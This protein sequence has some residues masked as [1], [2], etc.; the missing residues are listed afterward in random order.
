MAEPLL[1]A[2][3]VGFATGAGTKLGEYGAKKGIEFCENTVEAIEK[4]C[5]AGWERDKEAGGFS[6]CEDDYD[7]A[8]AS[9]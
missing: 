9:A 6:S 7:T 8:S 3:G 1:T 2:F 4:E 5:E